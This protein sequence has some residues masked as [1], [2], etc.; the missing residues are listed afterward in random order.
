MEFQVSQTYNNIATE[1]YEAAREMTSG[2]SDSYFLPPQT[3]INI[4]E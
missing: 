4:V 2:S 3:R 1:L